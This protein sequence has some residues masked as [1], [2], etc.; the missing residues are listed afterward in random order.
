MKAIRRWARPLEYLDPIL[1]LTRTF[2]RII[3]VFKQE[4]DLLHPIRGLQTK[5]NG[6][7]AETN[8]GYETDFVVQW[9]VRSD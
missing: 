3:F 4:Y 5:S 2:K 7:K 1:C 8:V 9:L 6:D